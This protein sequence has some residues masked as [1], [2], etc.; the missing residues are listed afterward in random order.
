MSQDD[1]PHP[2]GI[3]DTHAHMNH[4]AFDED[5]D[6][7]LESA[8][9]DGMDAIIDVATEWESSLRSRALAERYSRV[10]TTVGVHPHEA[11][12][13]QDEDLEQLMILVEHPKV[14]AL[15]EMGLDYHYNFSDPA[16]QKHVFDWQVQ[17]SRTASLPAVVHIRDAFEDAFAILAGSQGVWPRGVL[18]CFT[19]GW[20][21]A[22][23]ALDGGF[24]ISFSGIIT[25]KRSD[26]M[27]E[28]ASKVPADRILVETDCP[29]LAPLP[30]RGKRNQPSHIWHTAQV[31]AAQRQIRVE[32]VIEITRQNAYRLFSIG[33]AS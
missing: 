16:R 17:Y 8:F 1:Q 7:V 24:Y 20:K 11:K 18:H 19:G 26:E 25:F 32:E 9:A 12:D 28:V 10:F 23:I 3:V 2:R 15:G 29:Y 21:D 4:K 13:Y 33:E 14:R 5:R 6:A 31:I 30:Y 27:R 22:Q